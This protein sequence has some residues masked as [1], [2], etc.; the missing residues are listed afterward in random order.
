MDS[1]NYAVAAECY[2]RALDLDDRS[3]DVRCDFG[4]CLHAMGLPQRALEEFRIVLAAEPTHQV[5]HFNLG[6]VHYDLGRLD[7]AR[8][9]WE[10]LLA[11]NPDERA[12][13]RVRELLRDFDD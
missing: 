8:Y 7:S 10:A 3:A 2:R 4:A 11:L 9:Y 12:A 6:I 5:V 13:E 1:F